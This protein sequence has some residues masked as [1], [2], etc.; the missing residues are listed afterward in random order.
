VG[1][2]WIVV[3]I[4]II[5]LHER[6]L[7]RGRCR[8]IVWEVA[9]VNDSFVKFEGTSLKCLSSGWTTIY[10]WYNLRGFLYNW[11]PSWHS[12]KARGGFRKAV[13]EAVGIKLYF[14]KVWGVPWNYLCELDYILISIKFERAFVK[15]PALSTFQ[16]D[17]LSEY[18]FCKVREGL[19]KITWGLNYILISTTYKWCFNRR[20]S[21]MIRA[22]HERSDDSPFLD[23]VTQWGGKNPLHSSSFNETKEVF[24]IKYYFCKV[25][26]S[27]CKIT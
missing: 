21:W 17:G 24:W 22:I 6:W 16:R 23:G 11:Q 13:W 3:L 4:I 19:C 12:F 18:Y 2:A 15:L 8:Q 25:Q 20:A 27:L 1:D 7:D 26:E 9:Y 5:K 14:C 10:F